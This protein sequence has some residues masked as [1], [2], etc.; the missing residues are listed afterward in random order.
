MTAPAAPRPVHLR[1]GGTSVLL[2]AAGDVP[3]IVHWG[4]DL[5]ELDHAALAALCGVAVRGV[6]HSSPDVP[7][8]LTVLPSE[9]DA[10]AG[11]P[12]V[13]G[14][15]EGRGQFPRYVVEHAATTAEVTFTAQDPRAGLRV[16]RRLSLCEAGL[17]HVDTTVENRSALPYDL[18]AV[19]AVMPVPGR[20]TEH[21]DFSGLWVAERQPHRSTLRPGSH[22]RE[23][24][25]GRPGHDSPF[26]GVLG[27]PG[28]GFR[29]GEVWAVHLAWSGNQRYVLDALPEGA[30]AA[31]TALGAGE[32]LAPGEVRL[33]PGQVHEA[34]TVVFAWSD[35]GLDGLAARFHSFQRARA[36]QPQTPAPLLVNTW[37]AVY[38]DHSHAALRPLV[39]AAASVGAERFVLDDGWFT[40]RTDDTRALG[41]WVVDPERWPEGLH[42]L[43]RD[44]RARGM[45]FGL[46]VEPEM[47]SAHSAVA[48]AH[49]EWLLVPPDDPGPTARHQYPLDLTHPDAYRHLATALDALVEE[50]GV[51]YLK[52]DHNRDLLQA[53]DAAGSPAV[54][55]QTSAVYRLMAELRE[56]H[57]TLEIES[58]ASGGGRVD[59]GIARHVDRFWA[60]DCND[61]V[62]RLELERWT[63]LLVP[64][65]MVGTH[66]GAPRAHTTGRVTDLSFRLTAA[67]LGH[68]GIEFDLTT[69][70]ADELA[71]ITRWTGY[72]RSLRP[73]LRTGTVVN[74]DDVDD[75]AVLRGVV[76]PDGGRA[77]YV[78]ARTAVARPPRPGLT[79]LP[80][81]DDGATYRVVVREPFG[82]ARRA[83]RTDPPW[84]R[85]GVVLGGDVLSGVG[86]LLPVLAPQSAV[87]VEAERVG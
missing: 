72:Y 76:A 10:W 86:V 82:P 6:A 27:T 28:F 47:V 78:W 81:L 46:W 85:D 58:C 30:G 42:P 55:A 60:S 18:S 51:D 12:A 21:L 49:P 79:P 29:R 41:D 69:A 84:V 39:E 7:R 61:P 63:T 31:A 5:G 43:V 38:F 32:L 70:S 59:L 13:A 77:T 62:E 2:D 11:H 23:G 15:T 53:Q 87:L 65:E 80:G 9:R 16:V 14:H 1:R 56:R 4:R 34:P 71:T 66:L 44:V 25:R 8:A 35:A 73:L 36:R 33:A 20:A 83:E 54:R 52:W 26:L 40:G 17:L 48:E 68:S 3:S 19:T 57:P 74:A 24:R 50:Y 22:S 64:P 45:Q 75:G 67:L 37:E